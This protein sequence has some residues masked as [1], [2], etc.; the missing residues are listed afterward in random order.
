MSAQA[1][2]GRAVTLLA[3]ASLLAVTGCSTART[4]AVPSATASPRPATATA[5][6]AAPAPAP[7]DGCLPASPGHVEQ[8]ADPGGGTLTLAI[9]GAGP[10]VVILS[11]QSDEFLCSWLPFA[12]RLAAAGYRVVLWDFG[13][14]PPADELTAVARHVASPGAA[15]I[16]LMGASEGA[17][18]SL[19]TA[20]RLGS[21]VS[22]VVS[23]SAEAILSPGIEVAASVRR[24]HCPLLL[25]TASQDAY[26]SAPAARQFIALAPSTVKRLVVVPG[27]DHGTALLSGRS[28]TRTVP[29]VISFLRQVLA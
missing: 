6:P 23:L 25:A 2:T 10:R 3:V 19:V 5:R 29:A 26:G 17:K 27:S 9:L 7:L 18:A 14:G 11:E 15:R 8:V 1:G 4:G 22:G 21:P 13:G 12:R 20:A 24:L 16:I 28:G